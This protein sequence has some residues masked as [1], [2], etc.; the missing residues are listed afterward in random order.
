MKVIIPYDPKQI[1]IYCGEN[2]VA[3]SDTITGADCFEKI[4]DLIFFDQES[5]YRK[6]PLLLFH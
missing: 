4:P 3:G 1:V 2:D 5:N 6:F